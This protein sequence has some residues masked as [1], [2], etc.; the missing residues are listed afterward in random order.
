ML[1]LSLAHNSP[2]EKE[3]DIADGIFSSY[4]QFMDNIVRN[5]S[6]VGATGKGLDRLEAIHN[7]IPDVNKGTIIDP[8]RVY[9][10]G[11]TLEYGKEYQ[12]R[13]NYAFYLGFSRLDCEII[14]PE[15]A[16]NQKSGIGV[17]YRISSNIE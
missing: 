4:M 16:P 10:K 12:A 15:Y 6:V 17:I 9:F 7:R 3:L 2:Q 11:V 8:V 14:K 13:K 5:W 1:D